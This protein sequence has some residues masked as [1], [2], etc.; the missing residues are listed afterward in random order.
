MAKEIDQ[1]ALEKARELLAAKQAE[2]EA[3][4]ALKE[5]KKEV[6]KADLR[7]KW[8]KHKVK[9]VLIAAGAIATGGKIACDVWK[10]I[11]AEKAGASSADSAS[12]AYLDGYKAG[13]GD[14]A[15][16]SAYEE[17]SAPAEDPVDTT[18]DETP[19]E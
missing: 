10:S 8:E 18:T 9:I 3:K 5:A 19:V 16:M 15:T 2:K 4:K 6:K 17:D 14:Y 1:E 11:R 12:D 13:W 7:E